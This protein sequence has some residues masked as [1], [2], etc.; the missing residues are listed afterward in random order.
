MGNRWEQFFLLRRLLRALS[1]LSV[2]VS[3]KTF[4]GI[5][6][7]LCVPL[8]SAIW[9][10]SMSLGLWLVPYVAESKHSV[11]C[12]WL[13]VAIRRHYPSQRRSFKLQWEQHEHILPYSRPKAGPAE[14]IAVCNT[15]WGLGTCISSAPDPS[16]RYKPPP[17]CPDQFHV[18]TFPLCTQAGLFLPSNSSWEGLMY[19]TAMPPSCST[20]QSSHSPPNLEIMLDDFALHFC[21]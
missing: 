16:N 12:R 18:I 10:A 1:W 14:R 20:T 13:A 7:I 2:D 5:L 19:T 4:E 6:K 9:D 11:P 21:A 3:T 15:E 8:Q 17:Y